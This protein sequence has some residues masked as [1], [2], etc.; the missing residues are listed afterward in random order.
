MYICISRYHLIRYDLPFH[1]A[2][3]SLF[4]SFIHIHT[5]MIYS[6]RLIRGRFARSDRRIVAFRVCVSL[7]SDD[8]PYFDFCASFKTSL[9]INGYVA[10]HPRTSSWI[11][12][13]FSPDP[14]RRSQ[15]R[16][17][18]ERLETRGLR[19]SLSLLLSLSP[20]AMIPSIHPRAGS[21]G[22][23]GKAKDMANVREREKG[24]KRGLPV[25]THIHM[26]IRENCQD[27]RS[28]SFIRVCAATALDITRSIFTRERKNS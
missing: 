24:G 13:R 5:I 2:C 8:P 27:E 12:I 21:F 10:I 19:I 9:T 25:L 7:V 28:S 11:L 3:L 20:N 17:S 14:N 18:S 1:L 15:F 4:L 6:Y 26:G 22:N 23:A 16:D